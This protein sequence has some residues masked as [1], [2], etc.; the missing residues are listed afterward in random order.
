MRSAIRHV[1]ATWLMIA[2]IAGTSYGWNNAGHM[3]IAYVAYQRLSAPAKA[4]VDALVRLNPHFEKWSA[5]IPAETP[6]AKKP[7]MLFMMA[8]SWA[9]EIKGDPQY[10]SAD[11]ST[12]FGASA[13]IR[14]YSDLSMHRGWHFIDEPFS[15]DNTPTKPP[16]APNLGTQIPA[17]RAVLSSNSSD[18]RLKSYALVW[19]IHLVGDAHQPV[20]CS[21]RF[22]QASPKGDAGGNLVTIC[23]PQC[24]ARLHNFWD[25]LLGTSS[26]PETAIATG[27]KLPLPPTAAK[28]LST[29]TWLSESLT[30]AKTRVYMSPIGPGPGPFRLTTTYQASSLTL[31]KSRAVTAGARLANVLNAELK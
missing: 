16:A 19:L 27:Q 17:L 12:A 25:S 22:T 24:G 2:V 28:N 9:D 3:T 5:M 18:E 23:D 20:H 1:S 6:A 10:R 11:V 8:S 31:A 30:A 21:N 26:N 14:G 4:R 15:P 29:D 7:L 13:P